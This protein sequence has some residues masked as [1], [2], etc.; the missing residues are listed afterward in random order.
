LAVTEKC[1]Q[2]VGNKV[3]VIREQCSQSMWNWVQALMEKDS[4][5]RRNWVQALMEK[6]SQA[7]WNWVQGIMEKHSQAM[8]SQA[9]G[10]QA[11]YIWINHVQATKYISSKSRAQ[12]KKDRRTPVVVYKELLITD[13][14]TPAGRRYRM[15]HMARR[16]NSTPRQAPP[17]RLPQA[18]RRS[19]LLH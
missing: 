5:S 6:H 3:R 4:Q 9:V 7:M 18:R 19:S 1:N 2:T 10:N 13:T 12:A 8:H 11:Q 14:E 17:L 16:E 15:C